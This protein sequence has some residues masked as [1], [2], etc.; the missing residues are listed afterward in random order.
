[1]TEKRV[2]GRATPCVSTYELSHI[3]LGGAETHWRRQACSGPG[4]TINHMILSR[5]AGIA[6][7]V[8]LLRTQVNFSTALPNTY[9]PPNRTHPFTPRSHTH[10]TYGRSIRPESSAESRRGAVKLPPS[11]LPLS[12]C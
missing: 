3:P 10:Y 1:M 7:E 8:R 5:A 12:A 4:S 9:L 6:C 2:F 11:F